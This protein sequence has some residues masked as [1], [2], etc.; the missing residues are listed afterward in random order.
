MRTKD[1]VPGLLTTQAAA[2]ARSNGHI[3]GKT[4]DLTDRLWYCSEKERKMVNN[5]LEMKEN[6]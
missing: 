1:R 5:T 2:I 6:S 3:L 4:R